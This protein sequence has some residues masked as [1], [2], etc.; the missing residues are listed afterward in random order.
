VAPDGTILMATADTP[1]LQYR[2]RKRRLAIHA[3]LFA[4]LNGFFVGQWLLLRDAPL[5]DV[6]PRVF[7]SFWPVW[8][9]LLWGVVLGIHGLY[10][11]ARKPVVEIE[12]PRPVS[13]RFVPTS[14]SSASSRLTP[15]IDGN[16]PR[17]IAEGA[18]MKMQ[19]GWSE[20]GRS[21]HFMP[22]K[23]PIRSPAR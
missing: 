11:W 1:T 9:V 4:I 20:P 12:A 22:L 23:S 19:G 3:A 2:R 14:R 7:A 13:W 5:E 15:S 17:D 18:C 16:F 10:V 6:D 8:L 21:G